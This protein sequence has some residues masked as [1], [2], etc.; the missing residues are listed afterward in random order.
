MVARGYCPAHGQSRE[1]GRASSNARGYTR[2]WGKRAT[3]FLQ[4]YPLCG[5]RPGGLAPV[6]SACHAAGIRTPATQVDHVIPHRGDPRLYEDLEGNGQ[7]LCASCGSK[8]TRAG[9]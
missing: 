6:M 8:K 2:A 9:L 7:A 4:A 1:G 5:M 3:R